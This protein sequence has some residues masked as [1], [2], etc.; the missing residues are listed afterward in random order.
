MLDRARHILDY[1]FVKFQN[2]SLDIGGIL[3]ILVIAT[4]ARFIV[5]IIT[6]AVMTT[7]SRRKNFDIGSAVAVSQLAK[8]FI[9]TWAFII[10]IESL[11]INLTILIASSAA[12][13][14]GIGLG[15]QQLFNDLIS[16][17]FLLFERNV[18]V[19]DVVEIDG[20][21]GQV[22]EINIRTSVLST[23]DHITIIVPNSKLLSDNVINWTKG[24][25]NTRFA[26]K[27]GVAYGSDTRLV[28]KLLLKTASAHKKVSKTPAPLVKFV[29]FG[30]SSL[31]FELVFW[32]K[33]TWVVE[34]TKSDLRF[35][36]DQ[37]FRENNVTI[38]FPQRDLHLKSGFNDQPS[39]L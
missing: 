11:G 36:I 39:S 6:K 28:E 37:L 30:N 19:E 3:A 32:A 1:D 8:Y 31:D 29:D 13:F 5:W 16:G 21:V 25:K 18:E 12:L 34:V 15:L 35:E 20:L 9:Y 7:A 38:P 2:F 17:I 4:V 23:R 27:V 22:L 26:I 24:N 10:S 33:D 14:V